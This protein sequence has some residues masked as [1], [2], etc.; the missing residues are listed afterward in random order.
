MRSSLLPALAGLVAV[1][2][3][4]RT[5]TSGQGE[6]VE[7]LIM[8]TPEQLAERGNETAEWYRLNER[9]DLRRRP[10]R[11]QWDNQSSAYDRVGYYRPGDRAPVLAH[12]TGRWIRVRS[13]STGATGWIQSSMP[14]ASTWSFI[15]GTRA[16]R[17]L[18]TKTLAPCEPPAGNEGESGS[19]ASDSNHSP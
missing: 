1:G 7:H 17:Y 14:R 6:C 13:P 5:G 16:I 2:C 11:A 3:S 9:Y 10:I 4:A 8:P 19:V 15:P 12:S 18:N